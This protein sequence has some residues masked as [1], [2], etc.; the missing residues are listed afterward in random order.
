MEALFFWEGAGSRPIG[1]GSVKRMVARD[2]LLQAR[3]LIASRQVV[4]CEP[5]AV[6]LCQAE[7]SA[8]TGL[9]REKV[10]TTGEILATASAEQLAAT[11]I[12]LAS[13]PVTGHWRLP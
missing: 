9:P 13:S 11:S 8:N 2:A 5:N 4:V 10:A 3:F 12:I 1:S 7:A 6:L